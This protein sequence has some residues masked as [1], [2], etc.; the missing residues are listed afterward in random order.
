MHVKLIGFQCNQIKW[1]LYDKC[2]K[3]VIATFD[4][5]ICPI[6]ASL[7]SLRLN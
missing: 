5:Q 4:M 1:E 7:V 2:K 3:K 6:F